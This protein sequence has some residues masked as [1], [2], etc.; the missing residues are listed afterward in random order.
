MKFSIQI[1]VSN[2]PVPF[3]FGYPDFRFLFTT[4]FELHG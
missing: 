2:D 4:V 1:S 3:L